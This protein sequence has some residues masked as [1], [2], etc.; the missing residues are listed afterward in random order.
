MGVQEKKTYQI[1]TSEYEEVKETCNPGFQLF[2]MF[3]LDW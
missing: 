1:K 3:I 2:N